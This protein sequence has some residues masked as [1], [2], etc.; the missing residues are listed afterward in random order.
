MRT[1]HNLL[2]NI[3]SGGEI[4]LSKAEELTIIVL[5][6]NHL[7]GR[8]GFLKSAVTGRTTAMI[9]ATELNLDF[10]VM[11]ALR[12]EDSFVSCGITSRNS[13]ETIG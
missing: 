13:I 10:S 5:S 11:H 12:P 8:Y 6:L 3:S 4:L 1:H 2:S 9:E 7:F